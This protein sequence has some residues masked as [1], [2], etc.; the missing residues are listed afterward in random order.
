MEHNYILTTLFF[1]FAPFINLNEMQPRIVIKS[2]RNSLTLNCP[3]VENPQKSQIISR[4]RDRRRT[5]LK[6]FWL[7]ASLAK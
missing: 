6:L 7:H 4:K 3:T 1:I 2:T 5:Y